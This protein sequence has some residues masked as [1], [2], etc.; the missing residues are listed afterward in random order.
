LEDKDFQF[1]FIRVVKYREDSQYG[2][3]PEIITCLLI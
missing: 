3:L 1:D 2:L